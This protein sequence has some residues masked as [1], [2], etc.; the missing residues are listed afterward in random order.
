M[1][2]I[3]MVTRT[4]NTTTALVLMINPET[5]ET[6]EDKVTVNG[7]FEDSKEL[8][9]AVQVAVEN[10]CK[11]PVHIISAN[12]HKIRVGMPEADFLAQGEVLDTD[13]DDAEEADNKDGDNA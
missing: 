7:V 1:A 13:E 5:R 11:V 3:R 2:K 12:Q 6:T 8:M 4:I 10:T 9:S